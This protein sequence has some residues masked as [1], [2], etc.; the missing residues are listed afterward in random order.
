MKSYAKILEPLDLG[1][2]KLRNRVVMGSI[3]TGLESPIHAGGSTQSSNK[4]PYAR[5]A[6]FYRDRAKGKAGLIITGG[7]SP[8]VEG[9]LNTGERP[10]QASEL[11]ALRCVPDAVHEEGGHILMQLLH[12]GRYAN[13]GDCCVAPSPIMSP[14]SQTLQVPMEMSVSLIQ[15]TVD[16][17]ARLARNAQQAGF[18]GV[19]I[20]G[21]EGYLLNQFVA[22]HTN[23]RTDD[24]GGSFENRIRFPLEV[25]RA[26]RSATGPNFII[27]FRVSLLDLVPDGSTQAEVFALAERVAK[28]GANIIN[29][30]IGWHEARVPTIATSVPRAGYVWATRAT[31]THLRSR[32][33]GIPLVAVNRMNHPDI[34]EQVLEDGDADMVAMARPFLSDAFFMEKVMSGMSD[35]INVCIGC[36]EACL[37][38]IFSGKVA[39]CMLNPM[40]AHE[41]ERAAL[42]TMTPKKIAVVGGGPAGASAAITLADRGH[43]VTLYEAKAILGGQFNLGKR[44][45]GKEEFQ[46]SVD[47]WTNSLQKH[48]NV[49]LKLNTK[50]TAADIAAAGFD[51]VIVA[52][53]CEP[54]P[55]SEAILP[56]VEQYPNVFN[57]VEALMHPEKVGRRVAVIGAGGIGFDMAEFLTSPH[58][59]S[60]ATVEAAQL[61]KYE[62]QSPS[63]FKEKWGIFQ[64]ADTPSQTPAGGLARPVIRPPFR[65]VTLF[66]RSRGK[67]GAHLG[68]STGWIHRLEIRMNKVKTVGGVTYKSFDGKTLVYAD[69]EGKEHALEVDSVVLC[70]GQ[71]SNKEFETAATAGPTPVLSKL[72]TVGG[73]NFTKKLDAKLA[74][75]QSHG[76][77]IRL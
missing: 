6:R 68:V 34:L 58:S 44:I 72:H 31:R 65:Q 48:P 8:S 70:T 40:A 21:S 62:K 69:G 9:E 1:F 11:D 71:S 46:S 23:H 35:H 36:N 3:H 61:T 75:L 7:F 2:V 57:Y 32:G 42:P 45:P 76:V 63:E 50:A 5:L 15:R 73:C 74:I 49:T 27:M 53:G 67:H 28:D 77:A 19:E 13:G 4:N 24:Y 43:H 59:T 52:T 54:H 22:R 47:Y 18:D 38:N 56:G 66:Q 20:M 39:S 16:D 10:L 60:A 37:D 64:A 12:P 55:K 30:G 51:E 33:I 26:V 25:L 41:E 17:F 29:S 14:I